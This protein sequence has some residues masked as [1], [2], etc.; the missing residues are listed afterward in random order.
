MAVTNLPE[1][2]T[3]LAKRLEDYLSVSSDLQVLE[4]GIEETLADHFPCWLELAP[5]LLAHLQF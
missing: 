2:Q 4:T 5:N 3:H 1:A